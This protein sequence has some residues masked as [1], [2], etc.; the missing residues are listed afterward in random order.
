MVLIYLLLCISEVD[1]FCTFLRWGSWCRS[2]LFRSSTEIPEWLIRSCRQS[3]CF[4]GK[5]LYTLSNK[6]LH[7]VRNAK[8]IKHELLPVLVLL[9]VC[10]FHLWLTFR[11]FLWFSCILVSFSQLIAVSK[12]FQINFQITSSKF[13][14]SVILKIPIFSIIP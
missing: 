2:C 9:N 1:T 4:F 3:V 8:K 7:S 10:H 6:L 12:W 13:T 5:K 11:R 14:S